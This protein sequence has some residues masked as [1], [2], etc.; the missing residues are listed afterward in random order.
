MNGVLVDRE[1]VEALEAAISKDFEHGVTEIDGRAYPLILRALRAALALPAQAAADAAGVQE[2]K[3]ALRLA[4]TMSTALHDL[5]ALQ[6]G[7]PARAVKM[8]AYATL[9]EHFRALD[10]ARIRALADALE[11]QG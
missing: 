7:D 5:D 8:L 3:H 1:V 10:P 6:K 4:S 2:V 11:V 9:L